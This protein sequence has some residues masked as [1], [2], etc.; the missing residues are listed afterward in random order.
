MQTKKLSNW[1]QEYSY[2]EGLE[3]LRDFAWSHVKESGPFRGILGDM[4]RDRDWAALCAYELQ[5]SYDVSVL[6]YKH[7][8]QAL[9]FFQKWEPLKLGVD[10]EAVAF[11]KFQQS[12]RDCANT[13]AFLRNLRRG[14]VMTT[15][16]VAG[17]IHTAQRK[18]ARVLGRVPSLAEL[19]LGFGPGATTT[20]KRSRACWATKLAS[21]L[22]CSANLAPSLNGLASQTPHWFFLHAHACNPEKAL[23]DVKVG[24]G[25]LQF[26][27]KNAKTYRSIVVEPVLNSF[28]Q[29]GIGLWIRDRLQRVGV[30]LDDQSRNQSLASSGSI[31]GNLATVDLSSASDTIS[32]ELV[33]ELLPLDWARF[34]NAFRTSKVSYKRNIYPLEKISS[35]GNGYTFELETLIFWALSYAVLEHKGLP[36]GWLA[37]YGDD[38]VL[39]TEGYDALHEV[40]TALGFTVNTEKSFFKGPFRE[41]CGTDWFLGTNIRPFYQKKGVSGETLFSLHNFYMRDF[42]FA[43]AKK[44][45]KLLHPSHLVFGPDGYGDGHLIGSWTPKSRK[46]F[47]GRGWEGTWFTTYQHVTRKLKR[48]PD[49]D[50][51]LP[52]LCAGTGSDPES[53]Y[54]PLVIPGSDGYEAAFVYTPR[55]GVFL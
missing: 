9:A 38:I 15:P 23:V 1:L 37:T 16:F 19:Q 3:I 53:R 41:S 48:L 51:A 31:T 52:T 30:D 12:E 10:K 20:T 35:M 32:M 39:P 13:N 8:R 54:D 45:R 26:V 29:H 46:A 44:V 21:S 40:F 7:A 47:R 24:H 22:E 17:V 49:T 34:L 43:R 25:R 6:H 5:Y 4:L 42:D 2:E 55:Q 11:R 50:W 36:T 18:I 14:A 27:P 33:Y 28:Y